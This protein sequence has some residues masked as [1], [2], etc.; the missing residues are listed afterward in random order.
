MSIRRKATQCWQRILAALQRFSV[1]GSRRWRDPTSAHVQS[2]TCG[3]EAH[4]ARTRATWAC[5]HGSAGPPPEWSLTRQAA[6][7]TAITKQ[8]QTSSAVLL[9]PM[10]DVEALASPAPRTGGPYARM[11]E[12]THACV[13][14]CT[15]AN[16]CQRARVWVGLYRDGARKRGGLWG[17]GA[18]CSAPAGSGTGGSGR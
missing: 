4:G 7:S 3:S 9:E 17:Y 8:L 13:C 6:V 1:R 11:C 2:K 5:V 12:H 15:R 14:V 16:L 18:I 10:M